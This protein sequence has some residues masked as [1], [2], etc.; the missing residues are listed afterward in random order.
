M[1]ILH[2]SEITYSAGRLNSIGCVAWTIIII[3]AH[4][5]T[6]LLKKPLNQKQNILL[7]RPNLVV[8]TNA[9]ANHEFAGSFSPGRLYT[10]T[11]ELLC[12]IPPKL[13]V[14]LFLSPCLHALPSHSHISGMSDIQATLYWASATKTIMETMCS[15]PMPI[16]FTSNRQTHRQAHRYMVKYTSTK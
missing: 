13:F 9:R 12:S 7:E 2:L 11:H 4:L 16:L 3:I 10:A 5:P 8:P 6:S 15:V 1:T 14:L